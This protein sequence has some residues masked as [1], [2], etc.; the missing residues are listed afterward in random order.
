MLFQVIEIFRAYVGQML[1]AYAQD[2]DKNWAQKEVC[3]FLV[4]SLA[5][6]GATAKLGATSTTELI[7]VTE[8]YHMHVEPELTAASTNVDRLHVLR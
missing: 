8:F 5:T 6:R 4:L 2:A 1:N 7:N 3:V